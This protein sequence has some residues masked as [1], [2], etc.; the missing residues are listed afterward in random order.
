MSIRP[1]TLMM[2][3]H[4]YLLL[5]VSFD[6][7]Y[8]MLGHLVDEH[9]IELGTVS[10]DHAVE[11][12]AVEVICNWC[13]NCLVWVFDVILITYDYI[14]KYVSG[15]TSTCVPIAKQ[16]TALTV[17]LMA[18]RCTVDT[19]ISHNPNDNRPVH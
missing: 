19:T 5:R 17:L 12:V 11:D 6:F 4:V 16:P 15:V 10:D 18:C 3:Y 1:N 2:Q 9:K 14:R 8:P 13:K 7:P